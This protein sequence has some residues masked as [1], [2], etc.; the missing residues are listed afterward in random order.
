MPDAWRD[1]SSVFQSSAWFESSLIVRPPGRF[2]GWRFR[3]AEGDRGWAALEAFA[4]GCW[5]PV[6]A[7]GADYLDLTAQPEY[8]QGVATAF[9]AYWRARKDWFWV[10]LPQARPGSISERVPGVEGFDGETCPVLALPGDWETMRRSLGKSLRG[11]LGYY[12]RA[13]EKLGSVEVR[14]ATRDTLDAD[15]NAF[16]QLHQQRWR[17]RWMPGAFADARTRRFHQDLAVRLLATDRLRLHTL[18]LDG[19]PIAAIHCMVGGTET[20]YYLGGFDPD[21]ARWSPGTVLT[22]HAIRTAIERDGSTRFEFL[23]GNERYK[24]KWGAEDR[25]NRR[26]A[27]ARGPIGAL[28]RKAGSAGLAVEL[29]LKQRMHAAHGGA[30]DGRPTASGK[31]RGASMGKERGT[32]A[33]DAVLGRNQTATAGKGARR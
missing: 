7:S 2:L 22:A 33:A 31:E 15:L 19:R 8:E 5:R 28:L 14:T 20:A 32:E 17:A 6:G 30:G 9:A 3:D 26:L 29:A 1:G 4:P 23:R 10:D 11:N 12:A 13:L 27:L 24:Y 25:R 18:R 16:T 21:F